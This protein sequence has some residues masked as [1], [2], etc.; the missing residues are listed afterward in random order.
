MKKNLT[1]ALLFGDE[2]HFNDDSVHTTPP[3]YLDED[4]LSQSVEF[5]INESD[6]NSC[7]TQHTAGGPIYQTIDKISRFMV[8][9][10]IYS[11]P[12]HSDNS[13]DSTQ[14]SDSDCLSDSS[15]EESGRFETERFIVTR[16]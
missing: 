11:I 10:D 9:R 6:M 15:F 13:D 7:S 12:D 5:S 8:Q 14:F 4:E 16:F 2:S 1:F 3:V